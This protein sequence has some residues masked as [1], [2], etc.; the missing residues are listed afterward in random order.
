MHD[1]NLSKLGIRCFIG[2]VAAPRA[3]LTGHDAHIT[4]ICVSAEHGL[5][6]SASQG[7]TTV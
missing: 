7:L 2:E 6:L 3:I 5:V 1:N 4:M